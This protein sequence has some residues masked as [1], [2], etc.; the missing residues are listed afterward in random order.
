MNPARWPPTERQEPISL[1]LKAGFQRSNCLTHF[2]PAEV[3]D[4]AQVQVFLL[5]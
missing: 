3:Y 5:N 4:T 1:T 2:S